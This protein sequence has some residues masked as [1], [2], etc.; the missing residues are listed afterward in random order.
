ML[1]G[2]LWLLTSCYTHEKKIW[3]G[4]RPVRSAFLWLILLMCVLSAEAQESAE[5]GSPG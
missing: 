3:S 4:Y 2:G 1:P 5:K